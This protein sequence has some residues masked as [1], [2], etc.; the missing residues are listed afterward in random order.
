MFVTE[1]GYYVFSKKSIF[2]KTSLKSRFLSLFNQTLRSQS[3]ILSTKEFLCLVSIW[4]CWKNTFVHNLLSEGQSERICAD[5]LNKHKLE[6]T[7]ID[8]NV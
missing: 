7:A 8:I 2:S 5:K 3:D 4:F 6:G 1:Q